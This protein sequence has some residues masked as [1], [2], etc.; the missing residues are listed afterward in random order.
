[1]DA[2][3]VLRRKLLW[4]RYMTRDITDMSRSMGA[5]EAF[6]G[7]CNIVRYQHQLNSIGLWIEIYTALQSQ[8]EISNGFLGLQ[9]LYV[10]ARV[11][12]CTY[13]SNLRC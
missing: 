10:Y 7:H 3:M 11:P 6:Q 12:M 13:Y 2:S 4:K 1:M 5:L 8:M 9:P